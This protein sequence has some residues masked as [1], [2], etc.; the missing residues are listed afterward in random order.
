L[1]PAV[2]AVAL[3]PAAVAAVADA[4]LQISHL[5]TPRIPSLLALEVRRELQPEPAAEMVPIRLL[6]IL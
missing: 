2:A 4:A 6:W 5:P 1:W 3:V